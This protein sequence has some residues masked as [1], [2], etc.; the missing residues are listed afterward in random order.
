MTPKNA[1]E[2]YSGTALFLDGHSVTTEGSIQQVA[3]WADNIIRASE[4]SITIQIKR[5]D[6]DCG[7]I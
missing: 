7:G 4:E 6:G 2:R 1:K 3:N 5:L